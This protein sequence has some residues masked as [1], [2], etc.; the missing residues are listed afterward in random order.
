MKRFILLLF[1]ALAGIFSIK[2]SAQLQYCTIAYIVT[3]D[4]VDFEIP[5]SYITLDTSQGN[6]WQIGNPQ[7]S[8]FS[9]AFNS[10]N[11]IVTDTINFYPVNATSSFTLTIPYSFILS[12][13][14]TTL[15][16][17]HKYDTDTLQDKGFIEA[18]YDGGNSWLILEDT[19]PVWPIPDCG[20][21]WCYDYHLSNGNYTVHNPVVS[22]KSDG[23]I[24]SFFEWIWF[25][26]MKT[27][28]TIICMPDSLML[29]F[30]FTSDSINNNKEG[31]M[32]DKIIIRGHMDPVGIDEVLTENS[33]LLFPN[34][35]KDE[36]ILVNKDLKFIATSLSVYDMYGNR[37][38]YFEHKKNY[39][40]I[41]IS[42]LKPGIYFIV[43]KNEMQ[44]IRSIKFVKIN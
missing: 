14:R 3:Q 28:D 30:S 34:P 26:G 41:N 9:S 35:A 19:F 42:H 38:E 6:I 17:W 18:S 27:S 24:L 20:F 7:K 8:F 32:I 39:R 4:S 44:S 23:W 22:G 11:A 33:M 31:W 29:R 25:M 10:S 12:N 21:S 37:L 13:T 43:F 36:I 40:R 16:F 2:L 15:T 1:T 5:S